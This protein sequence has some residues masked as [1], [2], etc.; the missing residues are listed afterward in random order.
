MPP[1]T[2]PKADTPGLGCPFCLYTVSAG[3]PLPSAPVHAFV[4]EQPHIRTQQDSSFPEPCSSQR[5]VHAKPLLPPS[6]AISSS[7]SFFFYFNYF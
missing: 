4:G 5:K 1:S 7:S 3:D 2:V 6:P